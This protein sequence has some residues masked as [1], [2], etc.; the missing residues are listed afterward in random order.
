MEPVLLPLTLA[1]QQA[2]PLPEILLKDVMQRASSSCQLIF[3]LS[4]LQQCARLGVRT[5]ENL[6]GRKLCV[7]SQLTTG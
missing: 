4:S 2:I 5:L 3:K 7:V 1:L 6:E